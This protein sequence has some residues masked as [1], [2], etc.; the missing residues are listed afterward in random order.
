MSGVEVSAVISIA[1]Y[2]QQA[3]PEM[4]MGCQVILAAAEWPPLKFRVMPMAYSC[5]HQ[6]MFDSG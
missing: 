1:V 3:V 2:P 5:F 4:I 6:L